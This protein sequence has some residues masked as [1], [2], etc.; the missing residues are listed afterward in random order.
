MFKPVEQA[1]APS[2][3]RLRRWKNQTL[4]LFDAPVIVL[5]YHRVTHLSSDPHQLAVTPENFQAQMHYL[6]QRCRCVRLDEEW[7]RLRGRAVAVTFDDGYAD[8]LHQAL[9]ILAAAGVPATFFIS[10]GTLGTQDEFWS[11]E[12]AGLVLGE[13]DRPPRLA[14]L[15][16]GA[17]ADWPSATR[18]QRRALH[19]RLHALM[20][21]RNAQGREEWLVQLRQWAGVAR[22][23]RQDYRA[24]NQEELQAL[25]ASP[26]VTIGAH[27]VSHTPLALLAA[28]EQR[29]EIV[30]SKRRLEA[31]L[32]RKVELFSYPFGGRGQYDGTTRRLCREEGFSRVVTTLPGQVH[33]WTD[34]LRLPRQM[35][36]NWDAATFAARLESFWA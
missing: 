20:L 1:L 28:E 35:V 24:L 23:G 10:T 21:Q 4:N 13:G 34:P 6:S 22:L 2:Y 5:A 25:A 11:D 8:N 17:S 26:W 29:Q 31:S 27:G 7:S 16:P 19:A 30:G 15:A 3:R 12:L 32:N 14:L 33:R 18:E 36:R 9:P